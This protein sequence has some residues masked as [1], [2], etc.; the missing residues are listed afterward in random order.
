MHRHQHHQQHHHHRH[1]HRLFRRE[2]SGEQPR[3]SKGPSTTLNWKRPGRTHPAPP[4]QQTGAYSRS[5]P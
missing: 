5:R 3:S 4:P 2:R 1:H